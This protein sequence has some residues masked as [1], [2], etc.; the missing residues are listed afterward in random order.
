MGSGTFNKPQTDTVQ[1]LHV[2]GFAITTFMDNTHLFF[3]FLHKFIDLTDDEFDTII[4][5]YLEERHFRNK[6]FITRTGD[7]ENYFNYVAKG[8]VRKYYLKGQHEVVTQLS[9]EGHLVQAQE[10]FHSRLPSEY[11]LQAIESTTLIS[12]SYKNLEKIFATNAK[13]ERLGRL[14]VTFT[15]VM[16]E[17]WF[18]SLIRLTPRERFMDFVSKNPVLLQRVPQKCLAS[19][20]NIQP[21]TFSRFKHMLQAKQSTKNLS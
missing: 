19:Y 11:N 16:K 12:I 10:S 5:P 17:R 8:L 7:V 18:T 3:L 14:V 13:M 20:L 1:F 21:E 2:S 4:A 9:P 15:M 6:Q